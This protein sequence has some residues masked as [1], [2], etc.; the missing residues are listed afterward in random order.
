MISIR[1]RIIQYGLFLAISIAVVVGLAQSPDS[2]RS[3]VLVDGKLN[4]EKIPEWVL[5]NHIF[6]MAG[7][8]DNKAADRGASLWMERLQLSK[9]VMDEIVELGY[10]QLEMADDVRKQAEDLVADSKKAN[11]VKINHPDKKKGLKIELRYKQH[12]LESKTLEIRDK[13]KERIGEDAFLRL[14]SY[15]RLQIAPNVKMGN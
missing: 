4:P 3:R 13:L 14:L 11:P 5:W 10:E 1:P 8:L 2:S 12:Y 9:A 7:T 15:A 6:L